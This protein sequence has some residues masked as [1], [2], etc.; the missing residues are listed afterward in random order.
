MDPGQRDGGLAHPH[1]AALVE[2]VARHGRDLVEER[3]RAQGDERDAE[4]FEF[5]LGDLLV[6]EVRDVGCLVA[7]EDAGQDEPPDA[8]AVGGLGEVGVADGVDVVRVLAAAG[9]AGGGGDDGVGAGHGGDERVGVEHVAAG[10]LDALLFELPASVVGRTRARTFLPRASSSST[11]LPPREPVAPTTRTGRVV[12]MGVSLSSRSGV[13]GKERGERAVG[14]VAQRTGL[15]WTN[16]GAG[17]RRPASSCGGRGGPDAHDAYVLDVRPAGRRR[18]KG[19]P[20]ERGCPAP[21]RY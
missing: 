2:R 13:G 1:Q 10:D 14:P 4:L 16:R 11:T 20:A 18:G 3:P 5:V 21:L 8:G 6:P 7:G 12:D 19:S 9:V 17:H 15:W